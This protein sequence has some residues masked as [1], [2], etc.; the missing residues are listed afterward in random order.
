MNY[1]KFKDVN[2]K[3]IKEKYEATKGWRWSLEERGVERFNFD[4]KNMLSN[5]WCPH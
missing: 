4:E 1:N 2:T 5:S 3:V